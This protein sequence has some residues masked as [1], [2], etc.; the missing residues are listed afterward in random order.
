[1]IKLLDSNLH[2]H[3]LNEQKS[4]N[5][6]PIMNQQFA[7][8]DA[9]KVQI[10]FIFYTAQCLPTKSVFVHVSA[11]HSKG[12]VLQDILV[13]QVCSQGVVQPHLVVSAVGQNILSICKQ[14]FQ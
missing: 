1:M 8:T 6:N 9:R 2:V 12:W 5:G 14:V 13:C 3:L 11:G 10:F 7:L 4:S